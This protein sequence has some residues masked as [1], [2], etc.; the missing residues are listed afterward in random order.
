VNWINGILLVLAVLFIL[1]AF[2]SI[3]RGFFLR[4]KMQRAYYGVGRQAERRSMLVNMAWG[5]FWLLL[6]IA[7][8]VGFGAS[9]NINSQ[10]APVATATLESPMTISP[11]FMPT[12][13]QIATPTSLPTPQQIA[14]N[15]PIASPTAPLDIPTQTPE[16]TPT[17][18]STPKPP[19][20]IVNSP[21]GLYLRDVAGGTAEV[22][23][24]AD[25]TEL[26]LLEGRA[27][28]RNFEWQQVQTPLGNVGWVAIDFL[29][30]PTN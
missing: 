29:I 18:T 5:A 17:Q 10:I 15:V 22:E 4:G 13:V 11:T 1:A 2:N 20:V 12:M 30:F 6:G 9:R 3:L 8:L 14:T 28:A 19:T 25:G 27:T 26:V 16:P 23:L 24:I 7:L 21:N